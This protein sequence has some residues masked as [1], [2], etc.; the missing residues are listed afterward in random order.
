MSIE[1]RVI[2]IVAD[3]LGIKEETVKPDSSFVDDLGADSGSLYVYYDHDAAPFLLSR[4]PFDTETGVSLA[5]TIIKKDDEDDEV[6]SQVKRGGERDEAERAQRGAFCRC[7]T[8]AIGAGCAAQ[9]STGR[10]TQ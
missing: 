7:R 2:K 3:Q 6:V 4:A 8:W 9:R 1:T 5:T 10:G